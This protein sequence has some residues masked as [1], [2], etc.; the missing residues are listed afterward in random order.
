MPIA[1]LTDV[2]TRPKPIVLAILDGW[3]VS[4][5]WGGNAIGISNPPTYNYLWSHY[6]H[7]LLQ[8]FKL[9]VGP[10]G[11]VGSSEIGHA[12]LGSGRIV[13]QD[14]SEINLLIDNGQFYQNPRL[15]EAMTMA[16]DADKSVHLIGL[17]S[18]GKIHAS[19]AHAHALVRLAKQMGITKLY[20]HVIADGEDSRSDS[21]QAYITD[22]EA[23]FA[24]E[25]VGRVAT[26]MG[27]FYAMDRSGA[28]DRTELSYQALT[29]GSPR[30]A[31]TARAAL[32][33]GYRDGFDD[34]HLP[35]TT[36]RPTGS[37]QSAGDDGL[38]RSG[39]T[40]VFWNIRADRSRQLTQALLDKAVFR[41]WGLWRR[42]PLKQIRCV[43][44]TD[45][46]LDLP[47]LDVAFPSALIE[48]TLG[49]LLANHNYTQLHV[50]ESE[51][52]AH[53]TY[54]FNGGRVQP[55]E[56]E[57]RTIVQSL[58]VSD[59]D[60]V[61]AMSAGAI[62]RVV[63]RAI[64][65]R[66]HDFIVVNYANVDVVAHTGNLE[67]TS[68]AVLVADEALRRLA[69]AVLDVGGLLM[70]TADHGNAESVATLRKGD[71]ETLHTRNPV[72]FIYVSGG[73][74]RKS[75]SAVQVGS[76]S[77]VKTMLSDDRTLADVAPTILELFGI[78][79]PNDMTGRSLLGDLE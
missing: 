55:Y 63:E 42:Y 1:A 44:L 13:E 32:A 14:L 35:P 78:A 68:R 64:Q 48:S 73:A 28:W 75:Q 70:I 33:D 49:Q 74:Q 38:I 36:I 5:S 51:K 29:L 18:E 24:Q 43:S 47:N 16:R 62:T 22:L 71:R 65:H 26:V 6:P 66:S 69:N 9:V 34:E 54:F 31:A 45:Y 30:T 12:T 23:L 17:L 11:T 46:H 61:P 15:Q 2:K 58:R 60:S 79:K 10:D 77:L 52:A 19:A 41:T 40:V 53:V 76:R 3:G 25:G 67:A 72:P 39:D 8:A 57:D 50:A 21:A 59:Y 7:T 27:R 56:G 4:P 20:V 37:V